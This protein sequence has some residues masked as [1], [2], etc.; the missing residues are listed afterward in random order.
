MYKQ[1]ISLTRLQFSY[2]PSYHHASSTPLRAYLGYSAIEIAR[3]LPLDGHLYSVE[4]D[5]LNAALATKLVEWAGLQDKVYLFSLLF[6]LVTCTTLGTCT[7]YLMPSR[8]ACFYFMWPTF[9]IVVVE[10]SRLANPHVE[11]TRNLPCPPLPFPKVIIV[12]GGSSATI[13]TLRETHKIDKVDVVF[14]D[15]WKDL[16]LPDLKVRKGKNTSGLFVR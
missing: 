3:H 1:N 13:P 12:I 8:S 10:G 7:I 9:S 11:R 14:L 6:F 5:P 16:Y 4:L 15:H 2:H